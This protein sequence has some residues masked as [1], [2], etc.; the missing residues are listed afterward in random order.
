VVPGR[1]D[2]EVELHADEAGFVRA[3]AALVD[4][5]VRDVGSWPTWWP[6]T[7][8]LARPPARPPSPGEDDEVWLLELTGAPGRRLR[9][10]ARF[11]GWRPD[12]G[13][14][15]ALE[16]DLVGRAEFWYDPVAGG[17]VVHHLLA[18]RSPLPR[19]GR[20]LRDHRRAV[21]RGLWG[22]KDALHLEQRTSAGLT[23]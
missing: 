17:T 5:R 9:L 10:E 11:H 22:L 14:R 18:A 16:G 21:R 12:A 20:V 1:E 6:G 2:A 15:M 23:P 4:R 13:I 3:P 19:P 8:V 7:R